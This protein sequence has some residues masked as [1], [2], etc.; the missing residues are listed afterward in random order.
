[1]IYFDN[2]ATTFPKPKIVKQ[3]AIEALN[4]YGGNPGRSGHKLSVLTSEKI[5]ETRE[6][7]A[8]FFKCEIE[9]VIFT[10]NCTH[11]LNYAMK[12]IMG[13]DGH[14]IISSMEHNAVSRPAYNLSKNGCS[15]SIAQVSNNDQVTLNNIESLIST[16]TK[17]VVTTIASNVTGQIMPYKKIGEMCKYYNICYIADGAQ[18]C[19]VLPITMN[20]GF[21]ILCTAGHKGLFGTSGTGILMTDGNFDFE[22]LIQGGTGATSKELEQTPFLPEKFESGTPNSLGI[23]SLGAGIDFINYKGID[24]IHSHEN[25]LCNYFINKIKDNPNIIIYRKPTLTYAPI[26][27]FNIKNFNSIEVSQYLNECGFG[28]RAGFHCAALAHQTLE[29]SDIGVVRFAPSVFNNFAE[30]DRLINAIKKI[31]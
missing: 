20:D 1:M 18:A 23:I 9:N 13:R 11:A 31:I 4:K 2:A 28:L 24:K 29:T 30:V 19:G 8:D 6:K 10:L 25:K 16:N 15:F 26:V 3:K 7:I 27:A 5:F 17:A 12:G 21:N 22:S 14:L